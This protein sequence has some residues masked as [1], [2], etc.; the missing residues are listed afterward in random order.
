VIRPLVSIVTPTFGQARFIERTI[1]SVRDQTYAEWEHIVVDAGSTDGTLEILASHDDDPRF[2][3][4]SEPDRGMYDGLRKGFDM[5]RGDIL[6]YLNSDDVYLPWALEAMV[7]ALDRHPDAGLAFGDALWIDNQTGRQRVLVQPAGR[8]AYLRRIGSFAQPATA[9]R[10]AAHESVGGF[11]PTLRYTGDLDFFLKVASAWA[12]VRV[13]EVLAVMRSH[14]GMKTVADAGPMRTENDRVRASQAR[15]EDS[16][17]VRLA[18]ERLRAWAA[19]RVLLLRLAV[20]IRRGGRHGWP[21]FVR[22]ARPSIAVRRLA[23]GLLPGR[24]AANQVDAIR[25]NVDWLA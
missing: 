10:R 23:L 21:G 20:S 15:P 1:R 2:R 24:F 22:G 19:R 13:D 7:T 4:I 17:A 16:G 5:A 12:T 18:L 9:W 6:A 8:P 14:P 3:W 11:D 25:S